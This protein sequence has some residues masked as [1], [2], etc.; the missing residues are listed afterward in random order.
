[1]ISTLRQLAARLTGRSRSAGRPARWPP[2]RLS[3]ETIWSGIYI[4]LFT[5]VAGLISLAALNRTRY[6][7]GQIVTAPIVARVDFRA[8]NSEETRRQQADARDREPAVYDLNQTYFKQIQ[9]RL[10]ALFRLGADKSI[11]SMNQITARDR[12][13]YQLDPQGQALAALR[14]FNASPPPIPSWQTLVKQLMD[15]LAGLAVLSDANAT[16]ER[17]PF[18]RAPMI[19]IRHPTLG[20]LDRYDNA[21]ISVRD[22]DVF[23]ERVAALVAR[24][25]FPKD[26]RR[27]IVGAVMT[28]PQPTYLLNKEETLKRKE[29]AYNRQPPVE[30]AFQANEVIIPAGHTLN[31]FDLRALQDEQQ[32]FV[33]GLSR[34]E[35]WLRRGGVFGLVLL[36]GIALWVYVRAYNPRIAGNP[37]RGLALTALLL[38]G[39]FLAIT[40]ASAEPEMVAAATGFPV[41]LVTIV[42]AIA[43]DRRFALVAGGTLTA[44]VAFTLGLSLGQALTLL[45]GAA[46]AAALLRE[47]STRSKLVLVGVWTGLTMAGV[48]LLV[49]L[50]ERYL[51]LPADLGAVDLITGLLTHAPTLPDQVREL[52]YETLVALAT[53]LFTGMFVQIALPAIERL[54]K[55][56]TAM[57]LKDLHDA[58][59]PLLRRLAQEAPGTYQHSLRLSD[60]ASAAADA[61]HGN[62]LL[63]KVGAMYHDIG[64]INKPPYFVENQAETQNRHTRLTP[65]M[66]LL[67]IV[68]HVRD[69]VELARAANL[70]SVVRQ[71]IETHHGTTLV[72]YFYHAARRQNEAAHLPPPAEV[73][74][75]YPGP[76]PQTREAAILMLCDSIES[77]ARTLANP[78]HARLEELV[79]AM[80]AKRLADGQFDECNITLAE[81]RK[82]QDAIIR[83]LS[84][85]YHGRIA[86]PVAAEQTPRFQRQA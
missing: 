29:A 45:A 26:L 58:S 84:A 17:D 82:V 42:L 77:A 41:L 9:D 11:V 67:I 57:T 10:D 27:C 51:A 32:A 28:H 46:V 22:E 78:S 12:E 21:I 80:A 54:F 60:I 61:I 5:I 16:A 66:S 44:L 70:P 36:L 85:M 79:H 74:F 25:P 59:H 18:Q 52:R 24:L 40:I 62:A 4:A 43:Y 55:V 39:H 1:M 72:E 23:R 34:T 35:L 13:L 56:T 81:L 33:Q 31:Q 71:F 75:R 30:R 2:R 50:V 7:Q 65:S 6:A 69:G 14:A 68:G 20:E 49:G 38:L 64:K 53:G 83:T 37:T 19:V 48:T 73:E 76:R 47:V 8:I 3:R 63:C 15:E 86:Y